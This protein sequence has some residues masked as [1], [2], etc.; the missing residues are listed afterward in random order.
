M[1][2]LDP[3]DE[4]GLSLRRGAAELHVVRHAD[5]VPESGDA[6]K[7]YDDYEA[8]PLSERGRAQAVAVAERF[9]ELRIVAV[10]ASPIRRALETAE[11]I[12]AV[13]ELPVFEEPRVREI[14]IGAVDDTMPLRDRLAWLAM[15]AM[16]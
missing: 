14:P 16:R 2:R 4:L 9:G 12:A 8:H 11:G 13:A 1:S 6:F 5:A 15:V 10:Y 7:I 3:L